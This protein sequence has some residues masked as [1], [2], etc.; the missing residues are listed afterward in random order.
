MI[1]YRADTAL[2]HEPSAAL[3]SNAV[4][5]HQGGSRPDLTAAQLDRQGDK[6]RELRHALIDAGI[7]SLDQQ[8]AALGLPRSTT[9]FVLQGMHKCSGL[10]A[11]LIARMWRAPGL[12]AAVRSVLTDYVIERSRGAYGHDHKK[13]RRFVAHLAQSGFPISLSTSEPVKP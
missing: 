7:V 5:R 9:W 3:R 8:A 2:P 10:R 1:P 4:A 11:G 12:P 6:I 13:R